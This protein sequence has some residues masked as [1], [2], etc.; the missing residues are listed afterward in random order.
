MKIDS[1]LSQ[2]VA[3]VEKGLNDA[4]QVSA[5]LATGAPKPDE[6]AG[7]PVGEKAKVEK[8]ADADLGKIVD[9]EA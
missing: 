6:D 8:A 4:R 3:G 9:V 2:A 7:N 1:V 5:Q